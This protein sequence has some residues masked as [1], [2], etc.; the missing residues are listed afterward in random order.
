MYLTVKQVEPKP[1]YI[2]LLTF[3]NGEKRLFSVRPYLDKGVFAEL[4]SQ[5]VFNSVKISF[6]SIEWG[7]GADLD[8]EMLYELST[9]VEK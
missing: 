2:L 3:S 9:P 1:D 5:A 6:D 8:P 7:N 4:R